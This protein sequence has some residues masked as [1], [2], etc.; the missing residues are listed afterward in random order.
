[1]PLN[2]SMFMSMALVGRST[3]QSN[4]APATIA[5]AGVS[6]AM[7]ALFSDGG[8]AVGYRHGHSCAYLN[9]LGQI[10]GSI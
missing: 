6:T 3:E 8:L 4:T 1:M 10:G 2:C 5:P 7:P 9:L